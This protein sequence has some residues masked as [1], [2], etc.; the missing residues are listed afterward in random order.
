MAFVQQPV[1]LQA[2]THSK[3]D[4]SAA[5]IHAE[6]ILGA[7]HGDDVQNRFNDSEDGQGT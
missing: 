7:K 6:D 2:I 4:E 3:V 5:S 1:I